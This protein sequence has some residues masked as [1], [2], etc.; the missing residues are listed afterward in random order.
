M[1]LAAD[2]ITQLMF[3]RLQIGV[4]L[5]ILVAVTAGWNF[6][7]AA[8]PATSQDQEF[9][10]ELLSRARVFPEIGAGVAAIK[11]DSA[12]RYY[13]LA[14]PAKVIA[15][16]QADGKRIGQ[17]PNANSRGAK[18]VYAQDIDVDS[19]GRLFVADRGANSVK[20][21]EPDGSLDATIP[22]AA[23]MSI[24]ALSG[25]E[26]AVAGLR[27]AQLVSIFDAQAKLARSFGEV[28]GD[29][30]G[31]RRNQSLSPGRIYGDTAEHIYFVF[32]DLPDLTLRRYDR[33]GYASY[34]ASL[35][36]SEFTPQAEAKRWTKITIEQG[37]TPASMKPAIRALG[38]DPVTQEIWV[39]IGDELVHFDKD[40]NR[41]AAYRTS[42][43]DGVRIEA[44]AILVEHD[45]ILIAAD[46]LGIF[47]FALPE[48]QLP[49]ASQE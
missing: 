46:T 48:R 17:I 3:R 45:R 22:F 9:S 20:I 10:R 31:A 5:A 21:F 28:P 4:C 13:V 18:I 26:F 2:K 12:G 1:P 36:S 44:S 16:Y 42:T 15:I 47:E 14:A 40:G 38:A 33:F 11:S 35:P 34:E 8:A 39:A 29:A 27:S 41:R 43:A 7:R 49:A 25:G 30:T 23:P 19:K 32:S 24:V 6:S 37:A